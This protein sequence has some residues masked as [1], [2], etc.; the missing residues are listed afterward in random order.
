MKDY[1]ASFNREISGRP[2]T[3]DDIKY[4][5]KIEHQRTFKGSD[6]QVRENQPFATQILQLKNEI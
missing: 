5:A 3:I 4:F 2:V 6:M 1:V